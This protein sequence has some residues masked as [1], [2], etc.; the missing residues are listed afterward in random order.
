MSAD[1]M[2]EA[3]G[4]RRVANDRRVSTTPWSEVG[5]GNDGGPDPRI[6]ER[7]ERDRV[8]TGGMHAKAARYIAAVNEERS[9][10]AKKS[11]AT[12]LERREAREARARNLTARLIVA[13]DQRPFFAKS[14]FVVHEATLRET[15]D[16]LREAGGVP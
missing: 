8:S 10:I 5:V 2:S 4:E 6:G 13:L 15:V 16:F 7:R 3:L 14:W 1:V 11:A 12:R 9:A